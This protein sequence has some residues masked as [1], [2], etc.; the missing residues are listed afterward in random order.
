LEDTFG[1]VV[2]EAMAWARPVCVSQAKFC[3]IAAHLHHLDNVYV[4]EDPLDS[5]ALR[6][7]IE[8]ILHA[9]NF[10]RVA[11]AGLDWSKTQNWASKAQAIEKIYLE[12]VGLESCVMPSA[13]QR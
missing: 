9:E 2:L 10:D 7:G 6:Q 1:M 5:A 8:W 13:I 4:L 11:R 3:G 12:S